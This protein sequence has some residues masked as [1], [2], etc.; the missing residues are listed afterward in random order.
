[1]YMYIIMICH[2]HNFHVL[3][4]GNIIELP[5]LS[6]I[7]TEVLQITNLM[8]SCRGVGSTARPS[9]RLLC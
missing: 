9:L 3:V 4:L 5:Q 8:L 1:M 6:C 2:L 7:W